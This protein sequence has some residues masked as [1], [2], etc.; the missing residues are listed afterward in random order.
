[1][2]LPLPVWCLPVLAAAIA[3]AGAL[4][5]PS[6][7]AAQAEPPRLLNRIALADRV[8]RDVLEPTI[9]YLREQ[10]AHEIRMT[11]LLSRVRLNTLTASRPHLGRNAGAERRGAERVV[12]VDLDFLAETMNVGVL[13]ALGMV[14]AEEATAVIGATLRDYDRQLAA[15]GSAWRDF[16]VDRAPLRSR[17]VLEDVVRRLSVEVSFTAA[18]WL[19]L[20]E[21]GHH[22]FPHLEGVA[23]DSLAARR[24]QEREADAW[25]FGKLRDLGY[26]LYFLEFFLHAQE[27]LEELRVKH[28]QATPEAESSHPSYASRRAALNAQVDVNLASP[29]RMLS[30]VG[31]GWNATGA[32]IVVETMFSR[33]PDEDMQLTAVV[34]SGADTSNQIFEWRG[35]QAVIYGRSGDIAIEAVVHNPERVRTKVTVRQRDLKSGRTQS[36]ERSWIQ[37]SLS[38]VR[39]LRAGD[40]TAAFVMGHPLVVILREVLREAGVNDRTGDAVIA[41]FRTFLS[42]LR[43]TL[44]AYA[45]GDGTLETFAGRMERASDRFQARVQAMLGD[46]WTEAIERAFLN[47]PT[48]AAMSEASRG[49]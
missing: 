16:T 2:R 17:P 4:A 29:A 8:S 20:H 26:Q 25:A 32:S 31:V 49:R 15:G 14:Q 24:E 38:P 10:A 7:A 1:M 43:T 41:E 42:T 46:K 33:K 47:N 9:A 28:G 3:L 39:H 36:V 19:V 11:T 13:A 35:T 48:L 21:I 12:L 40:V 45:K 30:F 5:F 34:W 6:P 44:I 27:F 18:A 37:T 23:P 22:V